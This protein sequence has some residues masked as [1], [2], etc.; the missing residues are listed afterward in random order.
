M[1]SLN[2]GAGVGRKWGGRGSQS[3]GHKT[4]ARGALK[5]HGFQAALQTSLIWTWGQNPDTRSPG[6]WCIAKENH[7]PR[8]LKAILQTLDFTPRR[9]ATGGF[10]ADKEHDLYFQRLSLAALWRIDQG[11]ARSDT[12]RLVQRQST[13][14]MIFFVLPVP[15][16]ITDVKLI[17]QRHSLCLKPLPPDMCM[18]YHHSSFIGLPHKSS[19]WPVT[20]LIMDK[21]W[22]ICSTA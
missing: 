6:D 3:P 19:G 15:K 22:I 21:Q 5:T 18:V 17:S 1:R 7:G 16:T 14:L 11:G 12:A 2:V 9:K 8:S 10:W 20:F 4:T 13:V